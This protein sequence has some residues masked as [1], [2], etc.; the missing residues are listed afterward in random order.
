MLNGYGSKIARQHS[1]LLANDIW[2]LGYKRIILTVD[3]ELFMIC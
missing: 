3:W 1:P 2:E